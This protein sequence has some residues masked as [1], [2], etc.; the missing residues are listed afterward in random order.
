MALR[1]SVSKFGSVETIFFRRHLVGAGSIQDLTMP[2]KTSN[3]ALGIGSSWIGPPPT[4]TWRALRRVC[5]VCRFE[6]KIFAE[7]YF[8]LVALWRVGRST[9]AAAGHGWDM[10]TS[11]NSIKTQPWP[12]TQPHHETT[13]MRERCAALKVATPTNWRVTMRQT[14][15]KNAWQMI[16]TYDYDSWWCMIFEKDFTFVQDILATWLVTHFWNHFWAKPFKFRPETS[17]LKLNFRQRFSGVR[18][19]LEELLS[20][21]WQNPWEDVDSRR[22]TQSDVC[23]TR[24]SS[25]GQTGSGAE[26]QELGEPSHLSFRPTTVA[27]IIDY[28]TKNWKNHC[29]KLIICKMLQKSSKRAWFC[30]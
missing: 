15:M 22:G 1:R 13:W 10:L 11:R 8:F 24:W 16:E 19:K 28:K 4:K 26:N 17:I 2:R 21:P 6:L 9:V 14:K 5:R 30:F 3:L 12:G 18:S 25:C 20:W 7:K 27:K 29:R 23:Q